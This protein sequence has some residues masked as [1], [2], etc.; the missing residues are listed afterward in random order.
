MQGSEWSTGGLSVAGRPSFR[1]N[2]GN[3]TVVNATVNYFM[4]SERQHQVQLRVVNLLD[5]KY[6]ERYGF[7]TQI[8]GSA[9]N[10]GEYTTASP[11]YYFGYPFEGKPRSFYVSLSTKF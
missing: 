11:K 2:F 5:E 7:G 6:A 1:K 8:Y 4:G 3:Y 9:Y 10:R